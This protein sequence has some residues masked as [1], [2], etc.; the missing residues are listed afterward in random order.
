MRKMFALMTCA[1]LMGLGVAPSVPAEARD[2]R[3]R[4]GANAATQARAARTVRSDLNR[5]QIEISRMHRLEANQAI[6]NRAT[7]GIAGSTYAAPC[8]YEYRRWRQTGSA[9]WRRRYYACAN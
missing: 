8:S 9:N 1:T 2:D 6:R 5:R 7:S 3:V 4:A